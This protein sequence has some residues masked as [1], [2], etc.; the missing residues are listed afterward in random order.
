M[1][2]TGDQ[3]CRS[4]AIEA[5]HEKIAII[6]S[7]IKAINLL[8]QSDLSRYDDWELC[9]LLGTIN[10]FL[11]HIVVYKAGLPKEKP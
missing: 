6:E 9:W 7:E 1:D 8:L 2:E 5:I 4:K 3:F 10:H 11:G